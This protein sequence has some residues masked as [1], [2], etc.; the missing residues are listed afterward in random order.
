M[1]RKP[2]HGWIKLGCFALSLAATISSVAAGDVISPSGVAYTEVGASSEYSSNYQA[3]NLFTHDMTGVALGTQ[4]EPNASASDWAINGNA[5][6]YLRFQLDQL[7][8]IA[9]VF[10]AQRIGGSPSADKIDFISLWASTTGP[11]APTDPGTLPQAI[12]SVTNQQSGIWSEYELAAPITGRY[13]LIKVEQASAS[14]GNIGGNE[15]RLGAALPD[16]IPPSVIFTYPPVGS[17]VHSLN[18]IE[19]GFSETV[20]GVNASDLLVNGQPATNLTVVTP[21]Q[22]VFGLAQPATGS[23]QVAWSP[24]HGIRDVSSN[25]NAFLGGSWTYTL[26]PNA[27]HTGVIISEFMAINDGD[28]SNS[29]TD[30]LGN[31]PDWVELYNSTPNAVNL[32]GWSLT[33]DASKLTKWRFPNVALAANGYMVVFA[34]GRNTNVV[35]QLHTSFKLSSAPSFLA[36]VDSAT[37]VVSTFSP[38]YPQQ[39]PD[40]SYGRDRLEPTLTGYFTDSTPGAANSNLGVG[41]GPQVDFSRVGGTFQTNFNL[42]LSCADTNFDIRYIFVATNTTFGASAFPTTNS[43]LYTATLL[44]SNTAQI[45]ART[46]PRAA[47]FLPGPLRTESYLRL[48]PEAATFTSD[49]PIIVLHNLAGGAVP[50]TTDQNA[51]VM[52]FEPINGHASLTNPPTLISRA[53]INIRGRSTAGFPKSSFAVELWDEF[54]QSRDVEFCGLPEE[55]DWVLYAPNCRDIPLMHNPLMHQLSRDLGRYSS[56]TRFAEVMLNTSGG[57][58]NFA[59]PA[60]GNYNGVYVVEE[61]IKRGPNRV[62][63][64]RLAPTMTNAPEITGGYLVKFDSADAGEPTFLAGGIPPGPDGGANQVYVYPP[65]EEMVSALRA[66]QNTYLTNLFNSFY[67]ALN[68]ANWTNPVTGYAQFFDVDAGIDHHLL[69]V[70]A[71]NPDAFRLSAYLFKPREGKITMGPLWDFDLGLGSSRF[72]ARPFNP[73]SWRGITYD[74]STDYF[75]ASQYFNNA[76]YHR[77]FTDPDFWQRY[78]D[79]YQ[80]LRHDLWSTNHIFAVV[81]TFADQLRAAQPR[82]VARWQGSG[83]SDT[84]PRTGVVTANGYSYDFGGGGDFQSEIDFLKHWLADR[85]DFMDTNFLDRPV[86]SSAGGAISNGFTLSLSD[87][88]KPGSTIYYTRDGSDPRLAGGSVSA[89]ASIYTGPL[90]LTNNVRIAARAWNSSHQNLTGP[91]NP[92]ISSSWS[93][94][95]AETYVVNP[96]T[97]IITEIMYHPPPADSGTNGAEDFEFIELKNVGNQ[98]VNL[99][100]IRFTNGIDFTFTATNAFTNLGVGQ[101]LVLAANSNV[102]LSRHPTVTNLAGQYAGRLRNSGERLYLEGAMRETIL[103]FSYQDDWYPTTDGLGFSLVPQSESPASQLW[104]HPASWRPSS[105]IGGSP[106]RADPPIPNRPPILINEA[107]T[108]TDLPQLDCVE[109]YNPNASSVA[110]GGWFLTDDPQ[111]PKKY[112]ISNNTAIPAGGYL[113]FTENQFGANGSNSFRLDSLGEQIY[114]FSGDGTNLT[115]YRHGFSYGPQGNE[116]SFGRHVSSDGIE[117]FVTQRAN[118]LGTLNAGPRVGPVVIN[119]IMASPPPFGL[120]AN[121]LAEYVE[122]RN[123]SNQSVPLFDLLHPTNT[124][125]FNDGIQFRFPPGVALPPRAYLLVVSF[126]PAHD[127]VTLNWFRNQYAVPATTLIDGPYQGNLSGE[128]ERITLL[129]PDQPQGDGVVPYIV[130]EEINYSNQAPWPITANGAGDSL[131]RIASLWFGDEPANWQAA[132]PTPGKVNFD[133]WSADSDSDGLPDEWELLH[134]LNA[135]SG[136]GGDGS[137]GDPDGDG[138]NNEQEFLA[139]TDPNDSQSQLMIES[140]TTDT[141]VHLNF[142]AVSNRTYTIQFCEIL[143]STNWNTLVE[144]PART[145]N[146]I[147]TI[148]DNLSLHDR[149]YRIALFG[150]P[151]PPP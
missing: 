106:G 118:T 31:H 39:Y 110:I 3:Q 125:Q 70:L 126:D 55:S 62:D 85:L 51:I 27:P 25:S 116:V 149:F 19:I 28:Q 79:R 104:S 84:S 146:Y 86:F 37:N 74:G 16:T 59:P 29:L 112:M 6:G 115:G 127:P 123:I 81:D 130:V 17:T 135:L 61:K 72:D 4:V 99:V 114:L 148:I 67:T 24:S 36:L 140:I 46:F 18:S 38:S 23:V 30:E 66:S 48:T 150:L 131:Q 105:A 120:S 22:F 108:H 42:A 21:A 142:Q 121:H 1:N 145:T 143:N 111:S 96:L 103:N 76:W 94:I 83:A 101:Y 56:R 63:V 40:V 53:G 87:P 15:L 41:F 10:Y 98:P 90:I 11:F 132:F 44:V 43:P 128:G 151:T 122:L 113:V 71:L 60:G 75:N 5:P 2:T 88:S 82:E 34:S 78:I 7:Q 97:L 133:A 8:N 93:G 124:W 20:G 26:N 35:G 65:G 32:A 64:D 92:P 138:M 134:N 45:R 54:D 58:L 57:A 107:L 147:S 95:R 9:S 50:Q 80:E 129:R 109:L 102:F 49:L 89:K 73:R 119:E 137:T 77:M 13:F 33:D 69:N 52:L 136:D 144:I 14:G 117:H 141:A 68:S 12:V 91:N 47:G 139:G 100:G